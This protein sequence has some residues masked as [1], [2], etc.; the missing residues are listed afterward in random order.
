MKKVIIID[1]MGIMPLLLVE[2]P[3]DMS[4]IEGL[5]LVVMTQKQQRQCL[6]GEKLVYLNP[7]FEA[8]T[9]E[10]SQQRAKAGN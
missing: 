4:I 2:E 5:S 6:P 1:D 7:W 10:D 9:T 8:T 3:I